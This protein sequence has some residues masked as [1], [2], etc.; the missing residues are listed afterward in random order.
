VK[1]YTFRLASVL[2]VR[3]I[4]EDRAAGELAA[5]Q[6]RER[7]AAAAVA[8]RRAEL[9]ALAAER[10]GAESVSAFH[11]RRFLLENAVHGVKA[12]EAAQAMVADEAEQR[13][14]T[15]VEAAARVSAIERLDDRKRE[16][17]RLENDRIEA[18]EV[19]DLVTG[20]AARTGA[21]R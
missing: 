6:Q 13:R 10:T 18:Q 11:A 16:D 21:H 15:W 19:D 8:A 3:R 7:D 14:L 5:A 12:A 17:H 2:R 20:R 4:E 9:D 1:R